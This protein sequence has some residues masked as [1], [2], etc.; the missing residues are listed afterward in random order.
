LTRVSISCSAILLRN[1]IVPHEVAKMLPLKKDIKLVRSLHQKKFRQEWGLFIVEGK[2][3]VTEALSSSFEVH[4]VYSTDKSFVSDHPNSMLVSAKEMEQMSAL[5]TASSHLALLHQPKQDNKPKWNGN[6]LVLD[7]ISDP[8]NLGTIMRSAEWFGITT[9]LCT[10]DCVE[11]YNP[12]VVQS[13]MG[14][15]FRMN[16]NYFEAS[17]LTH[18]IREKGYELVG[19]E[20]NGDSI[21]TF[22][23]SDKMAIVIGSESHGI[24]EVMQAALNFSI[25][26][27]GAGQ[28]ESLNAS[29]AASVILSEMSR[30]NGIDAV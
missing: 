17:E 24:R 15:V 27:P 19:A 21:Y 30:R 7:G 13:T 1:S 25:T 22:P 29:V 14:S 6:I 16:V 23:F 9:I 11:L 4:S 20:L 3:L 2:K 12:K 10:N 28:A 8:G 18:L 5:F 26:I